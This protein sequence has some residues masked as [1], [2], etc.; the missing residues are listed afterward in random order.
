MKRTPEHWFTVLCAGG[1]LVG[2]FVLALFLEPDPRG[3]GTHERFGFSPCLPMERW[4]I[5]CPGCGVTTSVTHALH[6]E[7]WQSLLVQPFGLLLCLI[8]VGFICWTAIGH[9]RGRDLGLRLQSFAWK[10]V[11]LS[12]FVAMCV[13]WG[14]KLALVH[15]WLELS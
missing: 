10:P 2:C 4:N 7:L 5:P 13:A 6:G 9:F 12:L 1:V 8:G 15:G 14:Y 3:Y 11:V